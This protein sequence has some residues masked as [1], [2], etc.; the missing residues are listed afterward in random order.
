M[1]LFGASY[2]AGKTGKALSSIIKNKG[3]AVADANRNTIRWIPFDRPFSKGPSEIRLDG[4][5]DDMIGVG[6][7]TSSSKGEGRKLYDAA[8][9]YA[10]KKGYEGIETGH[11][12]ISAPKTY[13]TY[14]HYYPD[15]KLI[16]NYGY[17]TNGNIDDIII[18]RYPNIEHADNIQ[19]FLDYHR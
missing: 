10:K 12:L 6:M 9:R 16:G 19:Q 1:D 11:N 17:W 3:F 18:G 2:L 15:R 7:I 14:Q 8:I 4:P 5:H 13:A